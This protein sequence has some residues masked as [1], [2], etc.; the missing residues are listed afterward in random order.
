MAI[1]VRNLEPGEGPAHAASRAAGVAAKARINAVLVTEDDSL[2]PQIGKFI[3]S[4]FALKQVDSVEQLLGDLDP[5]AAAVLLW[6]A[7]AETD[8]IARLSAMQQHSPRLAVL[9]LDDTAKAS[10]WEP[11]IRQNQIVAALGMP[12][13]EGEF[14]KR[15]NQAGE[16]VQAR[17][18]LLG[19]PQAAAG[20]AVAGA[21]PR[22]LPLLGIGVALLVCAAIA[23]FV[24]TRGGKAPAPAAAV[25]VPVAEPAAPAR[26]SRSDQIE[27]LLENA[28]QAMLERRYVAPAD[29]NALHFYR[30]VL[31]FDAANGE[32]RQG[33]DRLAELLLGRAQAALDQHQFDQALQSLE[34]ARNLK[35]GDPRV[36]ELDQR[37]S[38]MRSE[39]GAAQ[40]QAAIA[41]QNFDRAATLIDEALRAH[42]L[43]APQAAQMRESLKAQRAAADIDRFVRL[44][45]ARMQQDRLLEP[46]GDSASFYLERA[47]RAGA[48]PGDMAVET[49]QLQQKLADA[50]RAAID[51]R[52]FADADKLIAAVRAEGASLAAV[53]SLQDAVVAARTAARPK[54]E[55]Q[56]AASAP[57]PAADAPVT[58]AAAPA[59]EIP[60]TLLQPVRPDYPR[61]AVQ[62]GIEGWVDLAFL[63]NAEG[64]TVNV[65]VV[66]SEP[67]GVFDKA[68][69]AAVQRARYRP[70]SSTDPTV[71]REA[72]LRVSFRMVK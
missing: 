67:R 1:T 69:V 35:P 21:P 55:E 27:G 64:R 53:A 58:A 11:L 16:E 52:R 24:A 50:A 30:R 33:L 72:A 17:A 60:L 68:A 5:G 57:R 63:V 39:L 71:V 9:V 37:L 66:G 62:R 3:P 40:I 25:P 6:D 14:V 61:D 36:Q 47:R 18:A 28:G 2:W 54:S 23:T 49:R 42:T 10:G 29:N 15:L 4:R 32:A 13:A 34:I 7:R 20:G 31:S 44:A 59:A 48:Q 51:Q 46:A 22:K 56:P 19:S 41:A 65:H 8:V 70:L 26:D 12:I 43:A 45:Q 38:G